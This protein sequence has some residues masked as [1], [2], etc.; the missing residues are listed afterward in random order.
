MD[1]DMGKYEYMDRKGELLR[2]GTHIFMAHATYL[3]GYISEGSHY[4]PPMPQ[5]RAGLENY[6][7]HLPG[8]LSGFPPNHEEFDFLDNY[9]IPKQMQHE[10]R[11]D[12]ESVF[13]LLLWW[14]IQANQTSPDGKMITSENIT[15]TN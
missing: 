15:G 12:A 14:A 10:L 6:G 7:E 2:T 5:L 11:Y 9:V 4:F 13:W 1:F 3:G 8:R